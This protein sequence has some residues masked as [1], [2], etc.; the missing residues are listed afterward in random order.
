M[1]R[2]WRYLLRLRF[3]K[4]KEA[5]VPNKILVV[6]DD[7]PTCELITEVLSAAEVD[8]FSLTDSDAAVSR[9]RKEKFDAVFLDV[10][11]PH[12]G[13]SMNAADRKSG[14]NVRTPIVMISCEGEQQFLTRAFE[15]G[16]NFVLFKPVDRQALLRL[17]RV[18][19]GPIERERRRFTRVSVR[20]EVFITWDENAFDA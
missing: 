1:I 17:L 6:D 5:S 16:A 13:A 11:M 20:S 14:L 8:A 18:T 4:R 7:P 19:Q 3:R 12:P 15:V 10:R 9:L 2:W